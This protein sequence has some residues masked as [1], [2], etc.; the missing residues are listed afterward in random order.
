MLPDGSTQLP[1]GW[2]LSPV[3]RHVEIGDFPMA[4][5]VDPQERYAAVLFSGASEQG[6]ALV[7][8]ERL[9]IASKIKIRRA[10]LGVRFLDGG[11]RVAVSTAA[12][13]SVQLFDVDR[14]TGDLTRTRSIPLKKSGEKATQF[15]AGIDVDEPDR[16]MYVTLQ[17]SGGI[18]EI[19]AA[20]GTW[21]RTVPVGPHPYLCRISKDRKRLFVSLWSEKRL[22]VLDRATL[23][24][25]ASIEVGPHPN[26]IAEADDGR[27]LVACA[28]DNTVAVVDIAR[29]RVIERLVTT[30]VP[31]SPPGSTPNAIALIQQNGRCGAL[32]AN[33]NNNAVA[34]ATLAARGFEADAAGARD[35]DDEAVE[36]EM[37]SSVSGFIPSGWYPTDVHYLQKSDR[38]LVLS[39]KGLQSHANPAGPLSPL[40]PK[41]AKDK[42]GWVGSILKGTL[43]VV[44]NPNPRELALWTRIAVNNSPYRPDHEVNAHSGPPSAIPS[45]Q[46]DPS[47]IRHVL[48]IIKEN[49][50]YD[51]VFGGEA[52]GDPRLQ[53]F[54]ERVTPNHHAL[55]RRFVLLDNTYADA[56]VSA[57]GHQWSTAAY[58]TDFTEKMWPTL[59]GPGGGYNYTF[60]GEG[61]AP[62]VEPEGGYLW[63][64]AARHGVS[65][66]SYGEF[67]VNPKKRD[68][69]VTTTVPALMG[70]IAPKYWGWDLSYRDVDRASVYIQE[71]REFEKRGEFPQLQI[72]RLPND[73][74]AGTSK[75]YPTP[76]AMVADNDLALGRIVEAVSKSRFWKDTAIF[77]VEDDAQNGPDH[78]D[79]H[80]MVSL[81]IS[82]WAKRKF[83]DSTLYTTSS[84]LRTIELIFGLPPMSQFDAAATPMWNSFV[85]EPDTAPYA[86]IEP[87]VSLDEMNAQGAVGQAECERMNL[88]IEDAVPEIEFNEIIWKSVRGADSPMP[89]PVRAPLVA[90]L[91]YYNRRVR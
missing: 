65:Y 6:L 91:E 87:S 44:S 47:P 53:I 30:F 48:Y 63:D 82:P 55:A 36:R 43:T 61:L 20:T 1:N 81:V 90:W 51:Q 41:D 67:V 84:V 38:I 4:V 11:T 9:E 8:L 25:E 59:Y 66:R 75:N 86:A 68:G 56:E 33:A 74:T 64:L 22:L 7:D 16:R 14:G 77:V 12:D 50:T 76:R 73:H 80:R 62:L 19:D 5:D 78:V 71:L 2:R 83:T 60:E 85:N 10:W 58:A 70:H 49:R 29:R 45:K 15:A 42:E 27:V 32:V 28:N 34:V 39:A 13:D 23:Q 46:G 52:N 72:L 3:G 21:L 88:T 37:Q 18:A 40:R 17:L 35:D 57:G 24:T 54:D 79:A 69:V 89:A 26:A 31:G